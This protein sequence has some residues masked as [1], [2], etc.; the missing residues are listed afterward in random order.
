MLY[1]II[2]LAVLGGVFGIV[3]GFA[4]KKFA[5][6]VDPRVEAIIGALPGANCGAC[7]FP[8][9][10]G[11]AEA[12]VTAGAPMDAC[13]PG[14]DAAK[15]K[16]AEIMGA[17]AGETKERKIAQLMCNGSK[18]NAVMLYAYEGINDC[19]AAATM[20]NGPK[21]CSFGCLGL[22]SCVSVCKF[23]AII[24]GPDQLPVVDPD[25]CTG[26]N[27]CVNNCPQHVLKTVEISK[28]VHVRCN[29][30]DKGKDAKAA[31]KVACIK[32]KICEKNCPEGAIQV[33]VGGVAVIDYTKC[34]SCGICAEKCPTKAIE[35]VLPVCP[36]IQENAATPVAPGCA[37]CGLCK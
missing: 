16:I 1:A 21:A 32:C 25:L 35:K 14:K 33:P 11:Y 26:C 18:D 30:K 24:I 2:S 9:C 34:T 10:S 29:N 8:G 12:I 5:V 36:T 27:A 13:A 23:D 7:G 19:H 37:G 4:G 6:E 15:N 3:L 31:C 28:L 17:E 20:Y 22:G